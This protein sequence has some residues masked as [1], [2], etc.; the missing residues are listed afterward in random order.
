MSEPTPPGTPPSGSQPG[1]QPGGPPPSF[2]RR[3]RV[4][5]RK[6][7]A[8]VWVVPVIAAAGMRG[9]IRLTEQGLSVHVS[10]AGVRPISGLISR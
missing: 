8:W 3:A 2:T 10:L 5:Q 1:G 7:V 6:F 4:R 9:R